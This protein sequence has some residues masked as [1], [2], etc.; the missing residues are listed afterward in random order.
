[1][2]LLMKVIF[3]GLPALV[4]AG[5]ILTFN[6]GQYFKRPHGTADDVAAHL[7]DA[8]GLALAGQWEEARSARE[9]LEQAWQRVR[10]RIVLTSDLDELLSFDELM[11]EFQGALDAEDKTQVHIATRKMQAIWDEFGR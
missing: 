9:E 2:K 7:A 3:F 1:M 5:T 11:A 8:S 4:L 6:A 10:R